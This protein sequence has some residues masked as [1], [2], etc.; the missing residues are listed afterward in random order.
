M[1]LWLKE[2]SLFQKSFRDDEDASDD[3]L[4][5]NQLAN[6][7]LPIG[8][9]AQ[10]AVARYEGILSPVGPRERLFRRLLSW[11]G[12]I[13]PTPETPFEVDNDTNALEPYLRFAPE[14]S[15][16]FVFAPCYLC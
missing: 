2:L 6:G 10:R 13:P 7:E 12:F 16:L 1:K 4:G 5:E 9:A 11:I 8:L 3:Q 14:K 15:F